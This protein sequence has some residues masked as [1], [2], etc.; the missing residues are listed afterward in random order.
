VAATSS[1][2][3]AEWLDAGILTVNPNPTEA[4]F[5]ISGT[6]TF[7]CDGSAKAVTVT[8]KSDKTT[9]TV[10]LKYN[11]STT[12][13]SAVGT[14]TVTF[15]VS[16]VTGWNAVTGLSAGLLTINKGTPV[17]GDFTISGLS[18]TY[19][20][21]AKAVT[22]TAND[23]KSA[24]TVTVKYNGSTTVPSAGGAYTVTFDVAAT[25]NYNA[26]NGLSAGILIINPR[27]LFAKSVRDDRPSNY[28][29]VLISSSLFNAVA[30]DSFGSVYAVGSQSINFTY[31][32]G[33]GV[34]AQGTANSNVVLVKYDSN[35]TA[36]W[37]KTVSAG[38]SFSV[39][40]AVAVDSSGNVYAA[41]YQS[42]NGT[43]TYGTGVS[44][45][46]TASDDNIV[47]V[48]YDSNGTAQWAKTVSAG[49]SA[50]S[51]NSVAV[52]SSGN[53]YAAGCQSGTGSYTYG[54]GVSAQGTSSGNNVVLVKYNSNGVAQWA[55]TVSAG[56]SASSF[57][58]VAVDSSGNVYAAGYQIGNGSYTYG[59]G[60]SAQGTSGSNNAV[61]VKY[62]N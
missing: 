10:T 8:A 59:T 41:G 45:Q 4:D 49:S 3:E 17:A 52:D 9:G 50:S 14:Y 19:D 48:K 60:V 57:N 6:G 27:T 13:P 46:G 32:Y 43:Y 5:T 31:T 7:N 21:N 56:S 15:D 23:G 40:N 24:G 30:V 28:P 36:Q 12:A 25:E 38:N 33:T 11:G 29:L 58:S 20:D 61:L 18:Q 54:T 44:A 55:K 16:A 22:V 62:K 2:N 39:F 26:A 42:G 1:W 51:F 47:L 34:S 35:G 53:V 37:A